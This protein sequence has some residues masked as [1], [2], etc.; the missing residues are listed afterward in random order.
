MYGQII[1]K[2]ILKV[3]LVLKSA[4]TISGS[5]QDRNKK[6]HKPMLDI[7]TILDLNQPWW[8][9]LSKTLPQDI[10][11]IPSWERSFTFCN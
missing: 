7:S 1:L 8:A 10:L 6:L 9:Q 11:E 3:K 4:V 5:I 2:E